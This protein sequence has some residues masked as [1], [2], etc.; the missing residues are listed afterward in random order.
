MEIT[1]GFKGLG[2]DKKIG[3]RVYSLGMKQN[4]EATA[5]VRACVSLE[6]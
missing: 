6:V 3:L 4:I 1:K 2:L 5:V